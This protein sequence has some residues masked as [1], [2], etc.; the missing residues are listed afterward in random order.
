MPHVILAPPHP[1]F[2][3]PVSA[4]DLMDHRALFIKICRNYSL[5]IH[6]QLNNLIKSVQFKM[7]N[8]AHQPKQ[9]KW[10]YLKTNC[11]R[12]G[13]AVFSRQALHKTSSFSSALSGGN[14]GCNFV[15]L[16][17]V[18]WLPVKCSLLVGCIL[19]GEESD[20]LGSVFW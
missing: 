15:A 2:G 17:D 8:A 14:M 20:L 13:K 19:F 10:G 12:G 16:R 11:K 1:T 7:A 9:N 4:P 3:V 5:D 18:F 6:L